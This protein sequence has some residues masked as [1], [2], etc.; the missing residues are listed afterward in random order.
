[1]TL[2]GLKI[3]WVKYCVNKRF[4]GTVPK[5]F[6]KKRK[7]LNSIGYNLAEGVR[8]V[9][10]LFCTGT[11][12]VGKNTWIGR[13]FTVHGN[14]NVEI[15]EN[16]DI[17]PDVIMQTGG[18]YI[19]TSN[20]RAGDGYNKNIT[21]GNGCWIGVRA[22]VLGGVSIGDGAVVGAC[23]LVNKDVNSNTLVAGVPAKEIR[24]LEND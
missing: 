5:Y 23:A 14:G 9:G 2:K 6:E 17:A 20:R 21:I 13:D 12:T 1:M 22:T 16:C 3:R 11:L 24:K 4:C 15:G 8:V 10:P 18:H 19:G 7:L